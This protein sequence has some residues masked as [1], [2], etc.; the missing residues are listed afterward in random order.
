MLGASTAR[1]GRHLCGD[2]KHGVGRNGEQALV[3]MQAEN[4]AALE[5]GGPGFHPPDGGVAVLHRERERPAHEG[6][7]HAIVL[8]RRHAAGPDQTFGAAADG[9]EER[10]HAHLARLGRGNLLLAQLRAAGA[11]IPEGLAL[12][13]RHIPGLAGEMPATLLA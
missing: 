11:D 13:L 2:R 10:A 6:R 4:N 8:A 12:H 1:R 7:T 9:A 5:F 3:G